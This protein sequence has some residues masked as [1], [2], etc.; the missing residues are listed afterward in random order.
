M[1]M[2]LALAVIV[3]NW[4]ELSINTMTLGGLTIAIGAIVD[5]AII[6]IE[7]IVRR[8]RQHRREKSSK[9]TA[10]IVLESSLEVR[11][12]IVYATLIEVMAL[13]PVF[14][15]EGLSGAFFRPLFNVATRMLGGVDRALSTVL[16][17]FVVSTALVSVVMPRVR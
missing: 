16:Y 7:N 5:D 2:S 12:A 3:M 10:R 15:M 6:D 14:F 17:T 1:P 13:A 9:S 8:L 11:S 4:L